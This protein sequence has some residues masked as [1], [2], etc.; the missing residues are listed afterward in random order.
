MMCNIHQHTYTLMLINTQTTHKSRAFIHIRYINTNRS[1]HHIHK[2]RQTSAGILAF[3]PTDASTH[4][5]EKNEMIM[6]KKEKENEREKERKKMENQLKS[7]QFYS[8]HI[9]FCFIVN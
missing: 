1:A 2:A 6:R 8:L 4:A 3:L 7:K 9:T 5:H